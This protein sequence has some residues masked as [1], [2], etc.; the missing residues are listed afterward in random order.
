MLTV[1][2]RME[3]AVLSKHGESIHG[4]ARAIGVSRNTVRRYL[5]EGE[6]AATR[7][8]GPKRPEKLDPFKDYIAE[9]MTAAVSIITIFETYAAR[10]SGGSGSSVGLI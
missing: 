9:R 10:P 4:I 8:P 7:K 5:R 3:I 2:E 6:A 1:E